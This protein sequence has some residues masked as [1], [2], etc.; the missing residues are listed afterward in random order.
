MEQDGLASPEGFFFALT[1]LTSPLL[2]WTAPA[3]M[4]NTVVWNPQIGGHSAHLIMKVLQEA[5]LPNGGGLVYAGGKKQPRWYSITENLPDYT[6]L[7]QPLFSTA[8][9]LPARTFPTTNPIH[10][11]GETGGKDYILPILQ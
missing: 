6:S 1:R 10:E 9:G 3:L 2:A 7:A 5:G 8:C 11:L 4:G